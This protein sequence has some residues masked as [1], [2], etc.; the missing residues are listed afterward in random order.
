MRKHSAV[1]WAVA[2]ALVT[3]SGMAESSPISL[4]VVVPEVYF[5]APGSN[6]TDPNLITWQSYDS[7]SGSSLNTG[8]WGQDGHT[9]TLSVGS[10]NI[11]LTPTSLSSPGHTDIGVQATYAVNSGTYFAVNVPFQIT[12]GVVGG[13][14]GIDFNI[15]LCSAVQDTDCNSVGWASLNSFVPP[16]GGTPVTGTFFHAEGDSLVL[17]P[18][19]VT[20]GQ[21][22]MIYNQ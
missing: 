18:T 12:L 11:T 10:G 8:L 21:L 7:F 14:G 6:Q 19:V 13:A 22:A 9:G 15:D 1:L 2:V 20:Q 16:D 5:A 4:T 3:V 17:E